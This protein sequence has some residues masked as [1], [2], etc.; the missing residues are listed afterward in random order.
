METLL[1]QKL[2]KDKYEVV[3]PDKCKER[4][5]RRMQNRRRGRKC[6]AEKAETV[7]VE[8]AKPGWGTVSISGRTREMED[9]VVVCM[10]LCRPEVT[11]LP[12]VH[13]FGVFDGH[14]GNH[15][16]TLCKQ[17]LHTLLKEE[18][19]RVS[20]PR[21]TVTDP[22]R[23][24]HSDTSAPSDDDEDA[25]WK[26][27]LKRTFARMD[28]VALTTCSCGVSAVDGCDCSE[29]TAALVGSTAVVAVVTSDKIIVAN[30]GDSRAVLCRGRGRDVPLSA[31]HKP[32]RPDEL[33]RI[34][35]AGGRV[36]YLD[37]ARV[38]GV[39]A[40]SRAIGDKFLK[41]IVISEPEITITRRDPDDE[42]L[43]LA[44]DGLWDVVP[45]HM[46]CKVAFQ[47][48]QL[49][50]LAVDHIL[51]AACTGLEEEC[52]TLS[53]RVAALLTRLALG[54]DSTDNISVIVVD[55]KS[56]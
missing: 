19:T 51:D 34:E 26:H 53:A 6:E 22:H 37:G 28:D 54:K 8:M 50:N 20:L 16:S 40:M 36:M 43:I 17:R 12:P 1:S 9:A 46:A 15:V 3:A 45:N 13:F 44:S 24:R 21:A 14:G 23:R 56:R 52:S 39:L 35:A 25:L 33:A 42:C 27:A 48:L 2:S 31:D 32:D 30:C 10:D 41:P 5:Q 7:A 11:G 49:G 18:L 55:L 38:Q 29:F 47:G 4:R